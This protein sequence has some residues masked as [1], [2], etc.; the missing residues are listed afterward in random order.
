MKL[1]DQISDEISGASIVSLDMD[2]E[3]EVFTIFLNNG[4]CL[5]LVGGLAFSRI[6]TERLH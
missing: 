3:S 1:I 6:D 5:Y 2:E 4:I